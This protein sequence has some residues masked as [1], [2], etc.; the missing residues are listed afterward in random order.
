MKVLLIMHTR[1]AKIERVVLLDNVL[2]LVK[3]MRIDGHEVISY[4]WTLLQTKENTHDI[5]RGH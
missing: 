5:T 2:P 4:N 3:Q 1:C